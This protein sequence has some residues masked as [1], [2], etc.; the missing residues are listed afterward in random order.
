MVNG[1]QIFDFTKTKIYSWYLK[2][3]MA[4]CSSLKSL[5]TCSSLDFPI[6]VTKTTIH[7]TKPV[8]PGAWVSYSLPW[9]QHPEWGL[10]QS[11]CFINVCGMMSE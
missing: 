3:N 10:A 1:Y 11:T 9:P 6:S 8:R 4:K 5:Q 7:T 2:L